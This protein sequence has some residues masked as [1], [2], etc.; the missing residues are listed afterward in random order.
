MFAARRRHRASTPSWAASSRLPTTYSRGSPPGNVNTQVWRGRVWFDE[1]REPSILS[2]RP[3][4]S[5]RRETSAEEPPDH[6]IG[7]SRGGLSTKVHQLVDGR[8][9]PLV[10]ALTPGQRGDSPSEGAPQKARPRRCASEGAPQQE[11]RDHRGQGSEQHLMDVPVLRR[12]CRRDRQRA[13][14]GRKP[15]CDAGCREQG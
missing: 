3:Q 15:C 9:R 8:G 12:K 1:S 2:D 4:T 10:I 11:P 5:S 14:I 6:A 13:E 7:R